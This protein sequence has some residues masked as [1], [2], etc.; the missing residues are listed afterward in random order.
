MAALLRLRHSTLN[1]NERVLEKD[2]LIL[3]AYL[4]AAVLDRKMVT[5]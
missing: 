1:I 3:L 4:F 5:N 2:R